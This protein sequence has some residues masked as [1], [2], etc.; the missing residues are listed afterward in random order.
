M[1][2]QA[3]PVAS[4]ASIAAICSAAAKRGSFRGSFHHETINAIASRLG[5]R[6]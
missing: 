4:A 1:Y 3:A 5:F 2:L 6:V